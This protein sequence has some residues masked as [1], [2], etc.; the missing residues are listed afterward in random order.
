MSEIQIANSKNDCNKNRSIKKRISV[1]L[2]PM[3][4]LGF[5]LITFFILTTSMSKPSVAK[6]IMPKDL[7][8]AD[9]MKVP[10]SDILTFLSTQPSKIYYYE[11]KNLASIRPCSYDEM[12]TVIINK[13][14]KTLSDHLFISIK[15]GENSNYKNMIDML[16]EMFI[17]DIKSYAIVNMNTAEKEQIRKLENNTH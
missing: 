14:S 12:S 3:F 8:G 6:L 13:K 15:P 5:L 4:D 9:S 7:P 1:D 10:E 16:D 17:N 2:T 11:G